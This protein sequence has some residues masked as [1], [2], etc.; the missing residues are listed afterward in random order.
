MSR[1][2]FTSNCSHRSNCDRFNDFVIS[3]RDHGCIASR[4]RMR[5]FIEYFSSDGAVVFVTGGSN[6]FDDFDVLCVA[7]EDEDEADKGVVGV[8]G[9]L[10]LLL[11][12]LDFGC[13][14]ELDFF[15][16]VVDGVFD[17]VSDAFVVLGISNNRATLS[18]CSAESLDLGFFS[19]CIF[20]MEGVATTVSPR[21]WS[22]LELLL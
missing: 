7:L 16:L 10:L 14:L 19:S 3:I 5:D 21:K 15:K 11:L 1:I 4:C 2:C 17:F 6:D 13:L 18:R 8:G 20:R 9:I 12:L 22:V